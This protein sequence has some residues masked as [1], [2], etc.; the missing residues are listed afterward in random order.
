MSDRSAPPEAS[1]AAL[2]S[3]LAS[4]ALHA[5]GELPGLDGKTAEPQ[6]DMA[7]FCI[8]LIALLE[9]KTSGNLSSDEASMLRQT[10]SH[11][12]SRAVR[13]GA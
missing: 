4:Q 10:L 5:L 3:V 6:P 11:L 8:D 9:S 13:A 1:F 2:L 12:R 7:R